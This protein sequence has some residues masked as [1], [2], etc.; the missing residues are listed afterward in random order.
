MALE[1][2][3]EYLVGLIFKNPKT[4]ALDY[5]PVVSGAHKRG[6]NARDAVLRELE[7]EMGGVRPCLVKDFTVVE[8]LGVRDVTTTYFHAPAKDM[9][10]GRNLASADRR[11]DDKTQKVRCL[12]TGTQ[13]ECLDLVR[14]IQRDARYLADNTDGID[15][16][17]VLPISCVLKMDADHSAKKVPSAEWGGFKCAMYDFEAGE[18]L[19]SPTGGEGLA[20]PTA[21]PSGARPGPGLKA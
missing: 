2:G 13:K 8:S 11:W 21:L 4:G 20:G 18:A 6:E 10:L 12:V 5:A 15:G 17:C 14:D 3:D 7:E 19:A 9:R 1:R 16:Y